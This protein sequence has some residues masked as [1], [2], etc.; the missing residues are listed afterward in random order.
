MLTADDVGVNFCFE[1]IPELSRLPKGTLLTFP[2]G[3]QLAVEEFNP[4]CRDMSE[5]LANKYR[6]RSGKPLGPTAFSK[7]AKLSRGI[8]G[9]VEAP[10]V[11][12]PGDPIELEI[13]RHPA[14][15]NRTST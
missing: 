3:A 12:R 5:S 1:G 9:V 6:T 2:S 13:Y 10:G 11:I 15:L 8:V 7:A 14:W 4:P